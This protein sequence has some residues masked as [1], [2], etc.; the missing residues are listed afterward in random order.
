[1][2]YLKLAIASCASLPHLTQILLCH[3]HWHAVFWDL[4]TSLPN[5]LWHH[6]KCSH[7]NTNLKTQFG[8][9]KNWP[10]DDRIDEGFFL[11]ENVWLF[12]RAAKKNGRNNEVTS[13]PSWP[14]RK[15]GFPCTIS[16]MVVG[17]GG[18]YRR[19]KHKMKTYVIYVT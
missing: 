5:R 15:A 12:C 2:I 7:I 10:S 1:M 8:P 14:G 18:P 19:P 4:L 17:V 11:Q 13:L 16:L 6:Q 3:C 9:K